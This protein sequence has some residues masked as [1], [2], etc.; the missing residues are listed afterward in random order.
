MHHVEQRRTLWAKR[1]AVHRMVRI[2]L[3]VDDARLGVLRPVTRTVDQDAARNCTIGAGVSRLR[4]ACQLERPHRCGQ[5]LARR[6]EA[7]RTDARCRQA[8]A[9]EPDEAATAEFH[10]APPALPCWEWRFPGGL[11]ILHM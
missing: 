11:F 1:A 3:D 2:A 4:G 5:R 10:G 8:D 7:Q 9:A 6:A